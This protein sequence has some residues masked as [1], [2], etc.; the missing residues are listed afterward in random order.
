MD[1][2][3]TDLKLTL[4]C[5][6]RSVDVRA[7]LGWGLGEPA[8]SPVRSSLLYLCLVSQDAKD[9]DRSGTRLWDGFPLSRVC[10][11]KGKIFLP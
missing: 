2:G 7:G 1:Q 11:P 5:K 10:E 9:I 8:E 3:D 6:T 4:P